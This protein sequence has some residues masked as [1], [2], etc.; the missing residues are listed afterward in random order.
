[1]ARGAFWT[2]IVDDQ[3]T[4]FRAPV[5]EDLLPTLKQLQRQ[6]PTAAIKWF[7]RGRLWETPGD[8][9]DASK[10]PR[11][12]RGL[13][14]GRRAQGPARS[15]QGAA[16]REARALGVAGRR[17]ARAVDEGQGPGLGGRSRG[18]E[19]GAPR[20]AVRAARQRRTRSTPNVGRLT[21]KESRHFDPGR[22]GRPAIG[23]RGSRGATA[24]LAIVRRGSPS[25]IDQPEIDQP[26]SRRV[27]V[28]RTPNAERL[29]PKESPHSTQVGSAVGGSAG[30][31]AEGRQTGGRVGQ[32]GNPGTIGPQEIDRRR[33]RRRIGRSGGSTS[34]EAERRPTVA[35]VGRRGSPGAIGAAERRTSRRRPGSREA[36]RA[37]RRR[38]RPAW[39][40]KSDRP[41]GDRPAWKPK[42]GSATGDRHR[43]GSRG[44]TRPRS[45]RAAGATGGATAPIVATR[46]RVRLATR[47]GRQ[48]RRRAAP[49]VPGNCRRQTGSGRRRKSR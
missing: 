21:P 25:R 47:R 4:A 42:S 27:T 39:K 46:P 37:D 7:Q 28:P 41:A 36:R 15:V 5:R 19:A 33:R 30:V 29:T 45:A 3:P 35:G 17:R 10:P 14:P 43:G 22:I 2:I 23:R 49:G 44:A 12:R 18:P 8:A 48:P 31:E 38:D 1:M 13:A 24:R 16:R 34:L 9:M 20:Q 40:P 32:R 6:H 26:G 11:R